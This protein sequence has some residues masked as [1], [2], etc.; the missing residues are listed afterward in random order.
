MLYF[1]LQKATNINISMSPRKQIYSLCSTITA[2]SVTEFT[3]DS[4]YFFQNFY[5]VRTKTK[6]IVV[7]SSTSV[8][9]KN[10]T[11]TMLLPIFKL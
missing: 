2:L 4:R 11:L 9:R 3:I 1:H 8:N 5:F 10:G 6:F 7:H